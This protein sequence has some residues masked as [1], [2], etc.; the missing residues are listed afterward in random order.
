MSKRIVLFGGKHGAC[1]RARNLGIEVFLIQKP[2]LFDL[3]TFNLCKKAIFTD[4][5]KDETII[6]MLRAIHRETPFDAVIS[7]T[8]TGMLP[9]ARAAEALGLPG[10]PPPRVVER[11]LDK[12]S[13][14]RHMAEAGF[15]PIAAALGTSAA[16]IIRFSESAGFP[17]IVKPR[18]GSASRGVMKI[19]TR[20]DAEHAGGGEFLME[21]YLDGPEISIE[22]FSFGGRHR[23]FAITQKIINEASTENP[24]VEIGH[25]LPAVLE[26]EM[27][28]KIRN[29]VVNF[30]DLMEFAD[31]PGHTEIKLTSN[32]PRI[33]ETHTRVGG[34]YITGLVRLATGHDLFAL[35]L[36]WPLGLMREPDTVPALGGAA[37]QFFTPPCGVVADIFGAE[38]WRQEPG[39]HL[40]ELPLKPGDR[41][42]P[43]LSS[44]DRVGYVVAT[45]RDGA[46]A[47]RL[48]STVRENVRIVV[49]RPAARF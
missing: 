9:A 36:G 33:V 30:L 31:G 27:E 6:P 20:A 1:D 49:D 47:A 19:A 3:Q 38:Y 34:D 39:V 28:N 15:T 35:T 17:V 23:I 25:Q 32:G 8:E 22:T 7:I 21:E 26:P 14:R 5:Q 43:I 18:D 24:Y 13:M 12:F 2:A 16:D 40:I 37:I 10:M 4:Y 42:K 44:S 29:Y 41:I 45:G 48:C 11:T 46:D